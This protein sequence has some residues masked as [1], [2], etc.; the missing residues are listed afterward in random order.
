MHACWLLQ[1]PGSMSST[2]NSSST[3]EKRPKKSH[4]NNEQQQQQKV[5]FLQ[6]IEAIKFKKKQ[7]NHRTERQTDGLQDGHM[8]AHK[9]MMWLCTYLFKFLVR[10]RKEKTSEKKKCKCSM[11]TQSVTH[12][13]VTPYECTRV[14][15]CTNSI[16]RLRMHILDVQQ[17]Q[18]RTAYI[19]CAYTDRKSNK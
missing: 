14:Y 7:A 6:W 15:G 1:L 16:R 4:I 13:Y 19:G 5:W 18:Q 12:L 10:S 8:H 11:S 3:K 9:C 2:S 17:Q